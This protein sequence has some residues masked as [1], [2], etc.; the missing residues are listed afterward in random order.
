M[1]WLPRE[2]GNSAAG[3][4]PTLTAATSGFSTQMCNISKN[5]VSLG[6]FFISAILT[7]VQNHIIK[8]YFSAFLV[9]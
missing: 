5:V 9:A 1:G 8:S 4:R 7:K 3:P 6:V 2:K